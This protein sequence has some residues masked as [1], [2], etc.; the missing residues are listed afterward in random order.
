M[1]PTRKMVPEI[2]RHAALIA[3]GLLTL[4]P[5]ILMLNI[6]LKNDAQFFTEFWTLSR[7]IQW[8]NF[9]YAWDIVSRYILNSVIVSGVS[10]FGVLFMA[11]LSAYSFARF[12]VPGRGLFFFMVIGLLMIPGVLALIPLFSL[13]QHFPLAGG[14]NILGQGGS[15][16]LNSRWGLILPYMAGGQI[17]AIFILRNFFEA[18]PQ[19][20]FDAARVDGASELHIIRLVVV[21]LSLPILI[22]VGL[23]VFLGTWNDYVWPLVVIRSPELRT[24]PVGMAF[25]QGEYEIKYGQVMAGYT[26][27]CVP[28][29]VLFVFTMKHFIQGLTL[30]AIKG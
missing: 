21:P 27:G 18:I 2:G 26:I 20:L 14:N 12:R 13:V 22:T 30:G 15:G 3:L 28:L 4:A 5:F 7:P 8:G 6:S 29:L 23:M 1:T 10:V 16:L 24:L 11:S 9:A 19:S 17:I 25:L